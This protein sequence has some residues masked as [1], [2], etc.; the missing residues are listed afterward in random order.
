M[1]KS[2]LVLIALLVNFPVY[3]ELDEPVN[4]EL[5]IAE[6]V[7]EPVTLQSVQVNKQSGQVNS[8]S[9]ALTQGTLKGLL[10]LNGEYRNTNLHLPQDSSITHVSSS[11]K[12]YL[13]AG[14]YIG[15]ETSPWGHISVG[16]TAY[17][18]NPVGNNPDNRRG[19]GGLYDGDGG[20]ASYNV[21]GEAYVKY[22][23]GEHLLKIGRQE[24]HYGDV[25]VAD[26]RMTPRTH[27]A[28][29]F[30]NTS[31][32]NLQINLAYV[33]KMK[34]RNAKHFKD[35]AYSS[36]IRSGCGGLD[37]SGDCVNSG[38]KRL[39]RGDFDQNNY[40]N[41]GQYIGS[42]KALALAGF[43][44]STERLS[45]EF[46]DYYAEDLLNS[47]YL[48]GQYNLNSTLNDTDY[49][50]S[51]EAQYGNQQ[52]A[53]DHIAGNIDT[54]YLGLKAVAKQNNGWGFFTS[55]NRVGYNE[56]SYNGGSIFI[57]WGSP[58]MFNSF[59]VQSSELAGVKSYGA[60]VEYDFARDGFMAGTYFRVRYGYYD[61]PNS[62]SDTDARQDRAEIT[63]DAIYNFAGNLKGLK[64]WLRYAYNDYDTNYD[65]SAYEQ[66]HGYEIDSVT[67]SFRDVR[68][69]VDYRF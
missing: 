44:Y 23:N 37:Q 64:L 11:E 32:D 56:D 31:F 22:Q 28:I 27:Q 10:R 42:K 55:Y 46:W 4:R 25:S 18:S 5:D 15:Y 63:F 62:L 29:I 47:L 2:C 30:E 67:D 48:Y 35:M 58:Q 38:S 43:V 59:Q 20:Q 60:G 40:G 34:E 49:A 52:D 66:I 68:L 50:Y 45:L 1:K 54:W 14:G 9:G 6:V 26:V 41:D 33:E 19:L 65:Y 24:M 21:I 61:M 13:S 39:L 3:A 8:L 16:A 69:Y 12:Q 57:P 17:T 51:I 7:S 53:G 36:R